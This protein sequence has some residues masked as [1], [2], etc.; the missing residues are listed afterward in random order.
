[1]SQQNI[2]LKVSTDL[3]FTC[4]LKMKS[5]DYLHPQR[6]E[7]RKIFLEYRRKAWFNS[8]FH[9]RESEIFHLVLGSPSTSE[10]VCSG[11]PGPG[12]FF[13]GPHLAVDGGNFIPL[14]H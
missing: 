7:V 1:M 8:P 9:Q 14:Y 5:G 2:C 13:S 4:Q 10:G 11:D 3:R 12:L 6:G